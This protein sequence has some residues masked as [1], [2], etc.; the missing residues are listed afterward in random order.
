M[1]NF[2]DS[3]FDLISNYIIFLERLLTV[4]NIQADELVEAGRRGYQSALQKAE[5]RKQKTHRPP[6]PGQ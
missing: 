6:K 4:N 5:L 3:E 1:Y 2:K